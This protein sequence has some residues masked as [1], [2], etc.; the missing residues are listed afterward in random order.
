MVERLRIELRKS[1]LQRTTA[2]QRSPRR[3]SPLMDGIDRPFRHP[4]VLSQEFSG[5]PGSVSNQYFRGL[6]GRNF[7]ARPLRLVRGYCSV[8]L[9]CSAQT[10]IRANKQHPFNGTASTYHT[11]M[12][13]FVV[14]LLLFGV[15]HRHPP[16]RSHLF[17]YIQVRHVDGEGHWIGLGRSYER[18][19]TF[20]KP[21]QPSDF[22]FGHERCITRPHGP[23]KGLS[24]PWNMLPQVIWSR[25]SWVDH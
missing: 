6:L 10:Q 19:F 12:R 5:L 14:G 22:F 8:Y 23:C 11:T 16:P 18:A 1:S 2:F 25:L 13:L 4:V 7:L 21:R 15:G 3:P 17:N 20:K 9:S 24:P